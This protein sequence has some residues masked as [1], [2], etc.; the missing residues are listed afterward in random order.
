MKKAD[1]NLVEA[2]FEELPMVLLIINKMVVVEKINHLGLTYLNKERDEV[3]NHLSGEVLNCV[4]SFATEGCGKG[5]ACLDCPIR[6]GINHVFETGESLFKKETSLT[7]LNGNDI[8]IIYI[9]ISV[10]KVLIDG[11]EK[12][13]FFIDEK[14]KEK[15]IQ[16][17]L[18][19]SA[20]S[21]RL[22]FNNM[23]LG[24]AVHEIICDQLGNPIDYK[25]LYAN[26]KFEEFTGLLRKN[27]IGKT[28]LQVLPNSETYWIEKYGKVALNN[29]TLEFEEYSRELNKYYNIKA[30]SP[31]PGRFAVLFSDVTKERAIIEELRVL[32]MVDSLTGVGNRRYLA[33]VLQKE[34]ARAYRTM[35]TISLLMIDADNFKAYN[36]IYGHLM[37]DECLIAIASQIKKSFMRVTD[38]I[39]RYGGEEFV[40]LLPDT[41]L[42]GAIHVSEQIMANMAKENIMH[43]GS[44][45]VGR[46]TVSIGLT[47]IVPASVVTPDMLIHQADQALYQAKRA[48]K[49]RYC[50]YE[51][52]STGE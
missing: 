44:G 50:I 40:V 4:N 5:E 42:K 8:S 52:K 25:F 22:L 48:G 36:D 27:V 17:K 49:N 19:E 31:S 39:A 51:P 29:E 38:F 9:C 41:D 18:K 15:K 30:Y 24:F 32:S 14:T 23:K 12:V 10:S 1:Q 13:L 7:T 37:G 46:L 43:K 3:L 6:G 35:E 45:P 33:D 11:E 47:S 28:L 34:T 16:N 26:P 20:T 21:F 2:L